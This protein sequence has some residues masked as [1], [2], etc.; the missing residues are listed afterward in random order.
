MIHRILIP[1]LLAIVLPEIYL[2]YHFL[3]KHF[4]HHPWWRLAWWVPTLI[5]TGYTLGLAELDSFAPT[6]VVWLKV[7]MGLFAFLSGP[8]FFFAACSFVGLGLQRLFRMRYNYGNVA[9]ILVGISVIVSYFYACVFG[10][11]QFEVRRV[12]LQ[13]KD[14]PASF[15]GYRIVLFSDAHVGTLRGRTRK[16]LQRNVD[17]INAQH[18]DLIAFTGDL[19]NLQPSEIRPYIRQLSQLKAKD[20]VWSVFGNHDYSFYISA[21]DY[22]KAI[23]ELET[24]QI[25]RMCGWRLL[26][27]THS[28][29]RRGQDSIV[30]AGEGNFGN[31]IYPERANL[32]QTLR[33]VN[34]KS[35][36]V[37]LQ[38]SP[39]AWH[40]DILPHSNVQLTLSGHT[41][42]GQLSVFGIRPT[43][44][45]GVP[46][47]GLYREGDRMLYVTSG[48]G[49]LVPFRFNM[50]AE[51]VVITLKQKK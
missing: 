15:N 35:F 42:G 33:G 47:F 2:D 37:M 36:V 27:N 4:S 34:S 23:N 17:S 6:D 49:A 43:A 46:D 11:R 40:K 50:P 19:Q 31:D 32:K 29:I 10:I 21:P 12:E 7:Y 1:L 22:V 51:I 45:H 24:R 25:E 20:G 26:E 39:V 38:H 5:M 48:S 28:G 9:G 14:L 3:R 16:L 44:L 41:H 13:F 8:K 18:P 30:I